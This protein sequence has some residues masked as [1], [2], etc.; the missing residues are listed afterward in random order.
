MADG[1]GD[2]FDRHVFACALDLAAG[3]GVAGLP[4]HLGLDR[5]ALTELA[6]T[7]FPRAVEAI[8]AVPAGDPA[9]PDP[10]ALEEDDLRRLL[11]DH[12]S[13]GMPAE[14]W[15][16]AIIAR[17]SIAPNHLWQDLGLAHRSELGRLMH[18]H[19]GPLAARNV[20][21]MKWK[22]FFYR[23]LCERDGVLVCKAPNCAV[24]DDVAHCFAPEDG[25]PLTALTAPLSRT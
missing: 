11:L 20:H 19:F 25:D 5:V 10:E 6:A 24:C 14:E 23:E 8:Q 3:D 1:R 15:L 16:A 7:Y 4:R 2:D 12:R 17:R 21:D 13:R 22:K 9:N 18:R